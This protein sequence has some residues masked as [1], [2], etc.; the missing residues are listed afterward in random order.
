VYPVTAAPAVKGTSESGCSRTIRVKT[1]GFPVG[2]GIHLSVWTR[3]A[4]G[5]VTGTGRSAAMAS[6][7][8]GAVGDHDILDLDAFELPGPQPELRLAYRPAWLSAPQP[9]QPSRRDPAPR[10]A[11]VP[12]DADEES[13]PGYRDYGGHCRVAMHYE[14]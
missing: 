10:A 7:F 2:A 9:P 4:G 12:V 14:L 11:R 8:I 5:G 6:T 3:P 13:E 1:C